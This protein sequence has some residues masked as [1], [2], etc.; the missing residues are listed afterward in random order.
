MSEG[1]P[2]SQT[3]VPNPYQAVHS[4]VTPSPILNQYTPNRTSSR[5]SPLVMVSCMTHS[6]QLKQLIILSERLESRGQ[7]VRGVPSVPNLCPK[8]RSGCTLHGY[9][10]AY[11]QSVYPQQKLFSRLATCYGKLYDTFTAIKAINYTFRA[12]GIQRIHTVCP[13]GPMVE[14]CPEFI[15]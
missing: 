13:R 6:L 12:T 11:S 1:Y 5:D 8:P 3:S 14:V 9:T 10:L 4:M 7:Y 2:L 15:E